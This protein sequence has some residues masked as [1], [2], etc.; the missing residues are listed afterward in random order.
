MPNINTLQPVILAG[1]SGTRLWPLSRSSFPKQFLSLTKEKKET[2][3]QLT[4]RRIS[5]F[6]NL[7]N[8][9]LICNEEHR[10]I[11][12]EQMRAIDVKPR[13]IFLEPF[14]RN[15]APAIT[16]AALK[17]LEKG[18]DPILLVLSADHII[19]DQH[20]FKSAINKGLEFAKDDA[21]VTFGVNPSSPETGFGYIE[22]E[23]FLDYEKLVASKIVTFVEKPDKNTANKLIKNKKYSWNSGMF[24]FK[25]SVLIKELENYFPEIIKHCKDSLSP[26]LIDL[27]FQRL[28]SES[29]RKCPNLS[30]D[31]AV[32]EKTKLGV[33]VPLK[34]GWSDLGSWESVL[35]ISDKDK[36][37]N[38]SFGNVLTKDCFNCF[39]KSD[40]RLIVTIGLNDIVV[41]ET[42]DAVLVSQQGEA[43]NLKEIVNNFDPI[44]FPEGFIHRKVYRPWGHYISIGNDSRWQVKKIEVDP[45]QTLSLQMHHHR[46]EHWI[47]VK[48]TAKVEVDGLT[49]LFGENQ[50]TYIPLGSKHRLSN[51]GKIPLTLIEVQ[52]GAY[53]GEDDIVRIKD[54]YGRK[55]V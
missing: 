46:A 9:I 18:E 39:V 30:I 13:S 51:P 3:L 14:G 21:L 5:H 44:K 34:A 31:Q 19:Q 1:G 29:F 26:E 15:T 22:A 17:A 36:N 37:G 8:P 25:A 40:N 23:D 27:D 28:N 49:K 42:S 52:S 54:I 43:H 11:A 50:S 33:V 32:M 35:E 12:A 7:N 16:I 10:F 55:D 47:I 20:K 2:M 4:L 45:G 38:A 53:L 24:L 6:E 41:V 48:G